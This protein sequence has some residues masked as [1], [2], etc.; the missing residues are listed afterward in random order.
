MLR[1][2]TSCKRASTFCR[3]LN[4]SS[5][6]TYVHDWDEG[7]QPRSLHSCNLL[8]ARCLDQQR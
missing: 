7:Y 4:R 5:L 8:D 1:Q 2:R 6:R 3:G